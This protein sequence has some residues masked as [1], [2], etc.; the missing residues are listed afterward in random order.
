M[1]N[2]CLIT[3][4]RSLLAALKQY[5]GCEVC[6]N[7]DRKTLKCKLGNKCHLRSEWQFDYNRYAVP[8]GQEENPK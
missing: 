7:Y 2:L 4:R 8:S 6:V 5:G 3:E 1:A